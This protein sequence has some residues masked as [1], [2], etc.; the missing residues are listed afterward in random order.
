MQDQH[1]KDWGQRLEI[2]KFIEK[3]RTA[4]HT[5]NLATIDL[6]FAEEAIIII[7]RKIEK[8]KLKDE[9]QYKQIGKQPSFDTIR[10]NKETLPAPPTRCIRQAKGYFYWVQPVRY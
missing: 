3:Y 4:F 9:L 2:V 6:M 8:R 10:M 5:R 1:G 7:G